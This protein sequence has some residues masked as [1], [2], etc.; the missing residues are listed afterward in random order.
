M[1]RAL[2]R[3]H[4]HQQQFDDLYVTTDRIGKMLFGLMQALKKSPVRGLKYKVAEDEVAYTILEDVD[5][6]TE[7]EIL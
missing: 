4:I 3:K 5:L 2:D 7:N 6:D 1:Y